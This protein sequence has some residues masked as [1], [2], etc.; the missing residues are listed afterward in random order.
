MIDPELQQ[1]QSHRFGL[2]IASLLTAC[3]GIVNLFSAVAPS[4][5][6]RVLWLKEIFP[7]HVRASGHIFAAL[8]GFFLLTLAA[9][10]LRR[11][12]IAWVLAIALLIVSVLSNLI[13]GWDYEEGLLS[14]ALLIQ[15][16]W[17]R[18]IFTARSDSPSVAQGIRVLIGALLFTLVYGTAIFYWRDHIYGVQFDLPG[19]LSQTLSMFFTEDNA[20]LVPRTPR[21]QF[22]VDSIYVVGSVTLI[23]ALGMILR[24]VLL[25]EKP[26]TTI[27]HRYATNIVER[28]GCSSLARFTLFDDKAYYFSPTGQSVIA[29]VPKGRVAI[30]LGDPIGPISDRKETLVGFRVF[31]QRNDWYPAFYQTLPD[32][33][34]LY[35]SIGFNTLQIGEEGSVDLEA[36]S[37]SGKARQDLRTS[38][39]KFKRLGYSLEFYD[40]PIALELLKALREISNEWLDMMQGSEKRF[41]L[42]WFDENY[43]QG[44]K[45][46]AIISPDKELIAFANVVNEY[47]SKNI[48]VDLMRRRKEMPPGTM[49]FLFVGMFEHFKALGY[50][51]F[52]IGLSAL[53]GVG[54]A[55]TPRRL[56]Q[57]VSYL[58]EHLNRFYGFKGLHAYKE[59]FQPDW[60]PRYLVYPSV[61]TLP[62]IV[63]ALIRADSGDRILDY[64]RPNT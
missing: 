19:A 22:F 6:D 10:L 49:D 45:I 55:E 4:F 12:R 59:K 40:P 37:L 62:E 26:A 48:T 3:T 50:K 20:G 21:G 5:P 41:S 61:I 47:Q 33:L 11:K 57:A 17:M 15:L 7:F 27:E 30:A 42:G 23:Y 8:S 43:L 58:Y 2:W 39:N 24:P 16:V 51:K 32:D 1:Q 29:Y 14:T 34:D 13:K 31:C 56:E 63:V 54:E 46:I 38:L 18:K 52:N 25:P 64:L 53:S 9:N 36:F 28:Y 44:C 60:E 35:R